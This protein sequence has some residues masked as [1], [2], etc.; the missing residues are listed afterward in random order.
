MEFET[1]LWLFVLTC[2]VCTGIGVLAANPVWW[3]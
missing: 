2:V 3:H 1:K